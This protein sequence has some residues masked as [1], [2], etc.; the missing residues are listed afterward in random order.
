MRGMRILFNFNQKEKREKLD[1]FHGKEGE[2]EKGNLIFFQASEVFRLGSNQSMCAGFWEFL[3]CLPDLPYTGGRMDA[4]GL[5]YSF[6][7]G[8]VRLYSPFQNILS[9]LSILVTAKNICS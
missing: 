8:R 5:F 3:L 4:V 9:S 6:I 2:R 1:R 7:S